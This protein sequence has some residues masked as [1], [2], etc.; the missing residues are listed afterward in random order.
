[1]IDPDMKEVADK[2]AQTD[3]YKIE[4]FLSTDG[5]HTVH[6]EAE[7]PEGRRRGLEAAMALYNAIE[8]KYGSKA[9]MWGKVMNGKTSPQKPAKK[10]AQEETSAVVD[11]GAEGTVTPMCPDCG[12]EMTKRKGKS[13]G[14]EFWGCPKYP[15]CKGIEWIKK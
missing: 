6:Y 14:K 7:T 12:E 9:D 3:E 15:D 2:L 5:K 11:E 8:K 10:V 13:S 1:M 4:L